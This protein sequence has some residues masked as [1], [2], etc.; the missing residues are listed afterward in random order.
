MQI[1]EG[2]R[3]LTRIFSPL[4]ALSV[5]A[6]LSGCVIAAQQQAEAGKKQLVGKPKSAIL[7]CAGVPNGVYRD[8]G[9]EYMAYG[10]VG[11]V[12]HG[13]STTYLGSGV[14]VSNSRSRQAQC[15][16]TFGIQNGKVASVNYRTAGGALIAPEEACGYVVR[17]CL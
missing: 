11:N 4:V 9:T 15:T 3:G 8:G 5:I 1:I 6:L 14:F 2:R 17:G 16:V 12:R 13:G 10:A 7:A